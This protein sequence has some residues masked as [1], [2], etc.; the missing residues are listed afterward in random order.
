MEEQR[1][2]CDELLLHWS[3]SGDHVELLLRSN[4][5]TFE[6]VAWPVLKDESASPRETMIN[7]SDT[8]TG[9][10]FWAAVPTGLASTAP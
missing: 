3:R 1:R 7:G 6:F 9:K 4:R 8:Y 5:D 2:D 10:V